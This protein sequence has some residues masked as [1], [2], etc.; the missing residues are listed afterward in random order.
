MDA[1]V[2]PST[3]RAVREAIRLA[4]SQSELA[5]RVGTSQATVWKW[6]NS[7]LAVTPKLVLKVEAATGI[8]RHDLRPDLYPREATPRPATDLGELEPAR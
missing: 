6:V 2:E 3:T 8:S 5:R 1:I 4:G 7:G